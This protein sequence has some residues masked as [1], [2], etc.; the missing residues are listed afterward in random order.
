M[1][2]NVTAIAVDPET[3]EAT[4]PRTESID[5]SENTLFED[6]TSPWEVED[7]YEL[8]WN[9]LND[10]WEYAFP[11]GKEKVKVIKVVAA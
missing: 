6:C 9:R 7:R 8:Y 11:V 1:I 3:G 2:F 4:A 5:T 10:G